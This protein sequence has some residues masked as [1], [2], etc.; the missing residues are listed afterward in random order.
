MVWGVTYR[1]LVVHTRSNSV[2]ASAIPG[3]NKLGM[4]QS[5]NLLHTTYCNLGVVSVRV[6]LSYDPLRL[7]LRF[8]ICCLAKL[9]GVVTPSVDLVTG[10]DSG[11]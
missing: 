1:A 6:S 9:L 4:P 3:N 10:W 5:V 11:V 7:G 8:P 2:F